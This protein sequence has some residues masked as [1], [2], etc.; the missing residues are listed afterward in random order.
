VVA[1]RGGAAAR[2]RAASQESRAR[3]YLP[4][5]GRAARLVARRARWLVRHLTPALALFLTRLRAQMVKRRSGKTGN[6]VKVARKPKPEA[7]P[8]PYE[9]PQGLFTGAYAPGGGYVPSS[10]NATG[11]LPAGA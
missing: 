4:E 6:K 11:R 3:H 9:P 10:M 1:V 8:E 5:N 7:A 2:E